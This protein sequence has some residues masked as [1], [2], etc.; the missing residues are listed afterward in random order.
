MSIHEDDRDWLR[1]SG[2]VDPEVDLDAVRI[3]SSGLP[4]LYLR[5]VRHSA[6]TFGD[7][8]WVRDQSRRR[9]IPLIA[10]E[11]VHVAQ[12]RRRGFARFL[13]RYGWDLVR[14]RGYGRELP[15]EAPAY[16]RGAEARR[17]LRS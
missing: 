7:S 2:L 5:I 11:L 12:Y 10:H 13:L 4:S 9:D 1:A 14:H 15:L 3:H 16:E 17:L 8:F 6:I